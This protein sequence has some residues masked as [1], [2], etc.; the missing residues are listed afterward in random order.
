MI[1]LDASVL[2]AHLDG[3]DPHHGAA[4]SLLEAGAEKALG[5]STITLAE[6]LVSP[7]RAGRLGDAERALRRL[8]VTELTLGENAPARLAQ[9]RADVGLKMPDC[10]VLL[11][12]QEHAGLL[13]SFD[14]EL[15]AAA[16]KLGLKTAE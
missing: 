10:C 6:T 2:I 4:Q 11:A 13:A 9:L 8:D 5:A 7:T 1:V 14:L 16:R 15:L 3:S 12:A